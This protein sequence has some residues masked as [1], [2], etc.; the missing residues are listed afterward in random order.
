MPHGE[1]MQYPNA[2]PTLGDRVRSTTRRLFEA[3]EG[4]P[5]TLELV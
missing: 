4:L 1:K 3:G 2:I 5:V